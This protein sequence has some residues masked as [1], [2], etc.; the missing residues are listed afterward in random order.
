VVLEAERAEVGVARVV[1]RLADARVRLAAVLEA[2]VAGVPERCAPLLVPRGQ[3][4]RQLLA[5]DHLSPPSGPGARGRRPPRAGWA[6]RWRTRQVR[7]RTSGAPG[8]RAAGRACRGWLSR[9][10]P[11]P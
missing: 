6:W 7:P 2:L 11:R 8:R 4:R 10:R 5:A 3:L 1:E 9:R